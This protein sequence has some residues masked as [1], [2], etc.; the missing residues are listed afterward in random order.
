MPYLLE[1][2]HIVKRYKN[3]LALDDVSIQVQPNSVF[4]LLG[5]NG[6]G[7]STLIKI[8]NKILLAD[9]GT[10]L[11]SG[12]EMTYE[13][14]RHIG[15]LPEE[16]GL[17]KKMKVGDQAIYLARLH[18]LSRQE[19]QQELRYWFEK[20]DI[21]PWWKRKVEE[22]SKGMQQKVQ[23]ICTVIH[24][25]KLLIFDEPFSGF[26]PVNAE[27]LKREI[28]E[29]RNN[30]CAVIFSTHNMQ[31]VEEICDDI[32]LINRSKVVLR[33]DVAEIKRNHFE[34]IASVLISYEGYR[35]NW[36]DDLGDQQ[37]ELLEITKEGHNMRIRLKDFR[38]R[39]VREL[40][41]LVPS[42]MH[43]LEV[44]QEIPSMQ[45]IFIRTTAA[46]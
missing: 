6:A 22:L 19:A 1:A 26:Y 31:S 17:Y 29:L 9:S 37:I 36:V 11:L 4:G 28:L 39:D 25:P 30:G 21:M 46:E 40:A 24:R 18:G 43:L 14:I 34:G 7:K 8:I 16:R 42:D 41:E 10:V 27:L 44:A 3:H 23:F 35:P 45:D 12:K 13:D 2:E 33:G 5:P 38:Q 20:F 15:Y 32:A